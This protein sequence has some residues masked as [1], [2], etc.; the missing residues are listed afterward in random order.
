MQGYKST[1]PPAEI[2]GECAYNLFIV[3]YLSCDF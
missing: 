2:V 3:K 1:H